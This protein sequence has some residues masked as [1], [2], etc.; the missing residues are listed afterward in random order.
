MSPLCQL[1]MTLPGGYPGGVWGDGWAE[2]WGACAARGAAGSGSTTPKKLPAP[3]S[4][5]PIKPSGGGVRSRSARTAEARAR[6]AA[7]LSLERDRGARAS[8]RRHLQP[9]VDEQQEIELRQ[10]S[11]LRRPMIISIGHIAP[12]P[13]VGSRRRSPCRGRR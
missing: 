7:G 11:R 8:A 6:S 2:R 9:A 4:P 1:D 12:F 3:L 13:L 10:A 5:T